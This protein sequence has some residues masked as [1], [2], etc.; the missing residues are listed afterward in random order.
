MSTFRFR[1]KTDYGLMLMTILAREGRG[2]VV[3]AKTM[4][5][6][7][8]PRS[9][10]VKIAKDLIKAGIVGAREGRGGG[11]Y[12]KVASNKISLRQIVEA[13]EGKVST[14]VCVMGHKLC[15]LEEECLHTGTM[16]MLSREI[17]Q[18][19]EKYT[20]EDLGKNK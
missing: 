10:L 9:F 12:L 20:L 16:K 2:E 19:L 1:K 7:G 8:L 13:V 17:E 5:K 11:Y 14:T 3:S 4:Q 15:P 18:I 6:L